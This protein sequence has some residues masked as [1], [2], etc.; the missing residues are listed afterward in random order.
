[1]FPSWFLVLLIN[2]E[3]EPQHF[4]WLDLATL[5]NLN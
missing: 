5:S 2:P 1:M 3:R 4:I